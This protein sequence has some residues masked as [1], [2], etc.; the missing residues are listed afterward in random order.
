MIDLVINELSFTRIAS[1]EGT[2]AGADPHEAKC[3]MTQFINVL[4]SAR[5]LG[6]GRTLRTHE[7]FLTAELAPGY[8][9]FQW[10]NDPTGNRDEHR[11]FGT[12]AARSPHLDG[13]IDAVQQSAERSEVR[14]HGRPATGL[15]AALLLDAI[16]ISWPSDDL[17]NTSSLLVQYQRLSDDA[18]LE[19]SD[20]SIPHASHPDHWEAHRDWIESKHKNE[21]VSGIELWE[22][23]EQLFRHLEFCGDAPAQ[24]RALSGNEAHFRWVVECMFA[25][26]QECAQWNDGEFPHARLPGPASGE[27]RSV[28][29]D[30]ELRKHRMFETLLG[31]TVMFEHHMKNRAE[32][33][34]VHYR[35]DSARRIVMVAHVGDKLPTAKYRT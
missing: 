27:S 32:N 21:I 5:T 7:A 20:T 33:L 25:A 34:R 23:R 26:E 24:I 10:R 4:R 14:V 9:L 19:E 11:F 16:A 29:D 3:W 28:H 22:K 2:C 31:Q 8:G 30:P 6:L 12:I 35:A 1:A 15:L 13:L 17:W 18:E